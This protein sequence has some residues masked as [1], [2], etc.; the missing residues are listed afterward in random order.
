MCVNVWLACRLYIYTPSVSSR[1]K[2]VYDWWWG[3]FI[4]KICATPI[5]FRVSRPDK[6]EES[7]VA[8]QRQRRRRPSVKT[9]RSF[10]N[11]PCDVCTRLISSWLKSPSP[12]ILKNRKS[13]TFGLPHF[14][15]KDLMIHIINILQFTLNIGFCTV[16]H[17]SLKSIHPLYKVVF[18]LFCFFFGLGAVT[19]SSSVFC[20]FFFWFGVYNL[21]VL[22]KRKVLMMRWRRVHKAATHRRNSSL[23][24]VKVTTATDR[25]QQR[26]VA[27]GCVYFNNDPSADSS[28]DTLL[29]LLLPLIKK[30]WKSLS[31]T[32]V[33]NSQCLTFFINR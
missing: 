2:P 30:I 26:T 29:R 15:F 13:K 18:F 21:L 14:V 9:I 33:W 23:D 20:C 22:K 19:P 27:C 11:K 24:C 1:R 3:S 16:L 8:Y 10:Q 28:T 25:Q 12:S 5:F 7:R 4:P 31:L 32:C 6:S 17:Q